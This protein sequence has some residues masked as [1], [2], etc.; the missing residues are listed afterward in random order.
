ME[1]LLRIIESNYRTILTSMSRLTLEPSL[2]ILIDM[3]TFPKAL[4]WVRI[5]DCNT[6]IVNILFLL[7]RLPLKDR[8]IKSISLCIVCFDLDS[9]IRT[10]RRKVLVR[11]PSLA[12]ILKL[13]N[14]KSI[15]Y[16]ESIM[17]HKWNLLQL[18]RLL[19]FL[20]GET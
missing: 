14:S 1:D 5:K 12:V 8:P 6:R 10:V 3:S 15:L 9:L 13:S 20:I 19:S 2:C 18:K 7:I 11:F 16:S 17:F 4:V